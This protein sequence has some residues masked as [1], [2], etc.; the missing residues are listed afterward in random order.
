MVYNILIENGKAA[1][2]MTD[3]KYRKLAAWQDCIMPDNKTINMTVGIV[4]FNEQPFSHRWEI[5]IDHVLTGYAFNY[6]EYGIDIRLLNDDYPIHV[7]NWRD[8]FKFMKS[9]LETTD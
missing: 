9:E 3:R 2:E 1:M 6:G 8:L 4:V 7:A 5:Y